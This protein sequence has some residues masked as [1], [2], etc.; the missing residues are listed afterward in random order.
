M[1][2]GKRGERE[3]RALLTAATKD[4]PKHPAMNG[5]GPTPWN[6]EASGERRRKKKKKR[7]RKKERKKKGKG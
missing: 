1:E 2:E 7:E 6:T 3:G 4:A 5:F